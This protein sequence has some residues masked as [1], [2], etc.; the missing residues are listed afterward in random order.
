MRCFQTIQNLTWFWRFFCGLWIALVVAC[1][2]AVFYENLV[3]PCVFFNRFWRLTCAMQLLCA[4]TQCLARAWN[5]PGWFIIIA[6]CLSSCED[7][8]WLYRQLGCPSRQLGRPFWRVTHH[9]GLRLIDFLYNFPNQFSLDK[10][11][12][13][14]TPCLRLREIASLTAQLKF[15]F[16]MPLRTSAIEGVFV[17]VATINALAQNVNRILSVPDGHSFRQCLSTSEK[18]IIF[19]CV[20]INGL[21]HFYQCFS[22][23]RLGPVLG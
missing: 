9:G 4:Q 22:W 13:I 14:V 10:W 19:S 15:L 20:W 17:K 8:G 7:L 23:A 12:N 21:T 6:L 2:G 11:K 18:T 5:P 3:L 16:L 1:A